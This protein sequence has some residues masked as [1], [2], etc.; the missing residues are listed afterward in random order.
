MNINQRKKFLTKKNKDRLKSIYHSLIYFSF[1]KI[2]LK[3][4][5][6]ITR[7]RSGSTCLLDLLSSHPKILTNPHDFFNYKKVPVNFAEERL[8]HSSKN[9]HGFKFRIQPFYLDYNVEN[10]NIAQKSLQNLTEKGGTLIHLQ[11]KNLLKQGISH[12]IA[13]AT[14]KENFR[15]GQKPIKITSV[16][17][18]PQE[19]M[20][21]I[22]SNELALKFEQET[23]Q[24]LP[25]VSLTYEKDLQKQDCHQI[26]M[27]KVCQALNLNSAPTITRYTRI[28]ANKLSDYILNY[29]EIAEIVKNSGYG[30]YLEE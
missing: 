5:I 14:K 2:K 18:D 6:V 12:L 30:Q 9:V 11:R 20:K 19:L 10:R 25:H 26:T 23:L 27:D 3:Y 24:E 17:I 8:I 28:S 22:K 21:Y 16:E 1:K 4:F 7:E 13:N 29:D 15:K